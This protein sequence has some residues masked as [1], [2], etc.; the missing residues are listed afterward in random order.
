MHRSFANVLVLR[1]PTA[2]QLTGLALLVRILGFIN[3]SLNKLFMSWQFPYR[4]TFINTIPALYAQHRMEGRSF[5]T[6]SLV[7]S[8]SYPDDYN[9]SCNLHGLVLIWR[10][11]SQK[12]SMKTG[13]PRCEIID[14]Y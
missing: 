3:Y 5:L 14:R 2:T 11:I 8:T 12:S 4:V 9:Q 6:L 10:G 13:S 7:V 1:S